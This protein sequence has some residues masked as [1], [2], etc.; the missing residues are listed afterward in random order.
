MT[1]LLIASHKKVAWAWLDKLLGKGRG[2]EDA[3]ATK[4]PPR[5]RERALERAYGQMRDQLINDIRLEIPDIRR[6]QKQ[7]ARRHGIDPVYLDWFLIQGQHW[8]PMPQ[9]TRD[10]LR[11]MQKIFMFFG[12]VPDSWRDMTVP[13]MEEVRKRDAAFREFGDWF[14]KNTV[15]KLERKY[16][17]M[18]HA[19]SR[20][21]LRLFRGRS[22]PRDP[23]ASILLMRDFEKR[24]VG[25]RFTLRPAVLGVVDLF[26]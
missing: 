8:P 4:L 16:I 6:A 19:K 12:A 2:R 3:P 17:Q 7:I 20:D 15:R 5:E 24:L 18:V 23:V 22:G 1:V 25:D 26:R 10:A 14:V 21:L 9:R 13:E 11:A